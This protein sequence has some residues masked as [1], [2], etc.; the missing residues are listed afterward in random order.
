MKEL[1]TGVSVCNCHSKRSNFVKNFMTAAADLAEAGVAQQ[2]SKMEAA[3][4]KDKLPVE[5]G[6]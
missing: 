2:N 3:V 6:F 5:I 1:G 4:P